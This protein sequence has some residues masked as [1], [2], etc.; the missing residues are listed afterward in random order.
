MKEQLMNCEKTEFGR[1]TF[2]LALLLL[3][4]RRHAR[5]ISTR[6]LNRR[7][8]RGSSENGRTSEIRSHFRDDL[9]G[10]KEDHRCT[11]LKIQG[12]PG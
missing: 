11:R 10:G 3:Y 7:R 1:S 4:L 6:I 2:V 9:K 8:K 5:D 12:G